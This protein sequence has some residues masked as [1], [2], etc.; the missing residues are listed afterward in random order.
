MN[1]DSF[2]VQSPCQNNGGCSQ[3]CVLKPKGRTCICG[4]GMKLGEDGISC[5]SLN[6]VVYTSLYVSVYTTRTQVTSR[7]FHGTVYHKIIHMSFV[8]VACP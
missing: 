8:S 5:K 3:F 1:L 2:S 7:I 4:A 6:L